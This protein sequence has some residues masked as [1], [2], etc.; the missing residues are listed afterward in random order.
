MMR[1]KSK[2][3]Q[4][5]A[6]IAARIKLFKCNKLE[7][8]TNCTEILQHNFCITGCKVA[9]KYNVTQNSCNHGKLLNLACKYKISYFQ[10]CS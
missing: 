7:G 1:A 2:W 10:T 4:F 5:C 8:R 3:K 9:V 6:N